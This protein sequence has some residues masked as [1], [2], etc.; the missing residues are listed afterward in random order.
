MKEKHH[1][2]YELSDDSD[3]EEDDSDEE[4]DTE[5]EYTIEDC[6]EEIS[7]EYW[8]KSVRH[9][10]PHKIPYYSF[11]DEYIHTILEEYL[12]NDSE[13]GPLPDIYKNDDEYGY[14]GYYY[15][16]CK[17]RSQPLIHYY[18]SFG[19]KESSIVNTEWRCFSNYPS[20]VMSYT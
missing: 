2:E 7:N 5:E 16:K 18:E 10:G 14:G 9:R 4:Y 1:T 13:K 8:I 3:E 20:L 6:C 19:F 15:N 11:G 12:T 17:H